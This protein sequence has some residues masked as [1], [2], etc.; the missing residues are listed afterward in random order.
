MSGGTIASHTPGS[1]ELLRDFLT[2]RY[3]ASRQWVS[4]GV[5]RRGTATLRAYRRRPARRPGPGGRGKARRGVPGGCR[6]RGVP[7]GGCA[8]VDAA[9]PVGRSAYV[10]EPHPC[11]PISTY[12]EGSAAPHWRAAHGEMA[13]SPLLIES[14]AVRRS[15][16]GC[17]GD[18]ASDAARAGR[19]GPSPLAARSGDGG[20][21][22]V[23][24]RVSLLGEERPA[25]SAA[26]REG[27]GSRLRA[28]VQRRGGKR[29]AGG[30]GEGR[31][32]R[33]SVRRGAGSPRR[34]RSGSSAAGGRAA[35]PRRSAG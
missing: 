14:R 31:K 30:A 5:S 6:G 13:C 9:R 11:R 34:W 25:Q 1:C 27:G 7:C 29:G 24:P 28:A 4:T 12:G 35:A 32:G 2:P 3:S 10:N 33:V 23:V 8:A 18:A 21:W 15:P 22:R 19:A 16:G 20:G 17:P 26:R